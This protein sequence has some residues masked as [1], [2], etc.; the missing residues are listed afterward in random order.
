MNVEIGDHAVLLSGPDKDGV[1]EIVGL[2][3]WRKQCWE[4]RPVTPLTAVMLVD[5]NTKAGDM[6]PLM[7]PPS[8]EPQYDGL[9]QRYRYYAFDSE[10][11]LYV[12]DA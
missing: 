11:R 10:L 2:H 1:V 7:A 3:P 9:I 5:D 6:L 12:A 8:E 4:I